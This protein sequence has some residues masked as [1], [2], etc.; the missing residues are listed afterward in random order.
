MIR[1]PSGYDRY[2]TMEFGDYMTLP[3]EKERANHS[4]GTIVDLDRP[5]TYYQQKETER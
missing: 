2:L 5:Y 3:P 4:Y 1:V